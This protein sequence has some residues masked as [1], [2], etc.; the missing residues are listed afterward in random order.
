[1]VAPNLGHP[2]TIRDLQTVFSGLHEAR[3]KWNSIGLALGMNHG[4]LA[5]IAEQHRHDPD[6]CFKESLSCCLKQTEPEPTWEVVVSALESP[7]VG[8]GQLAERMKGKYLYLPIHTSDS[9][10]EHF[11][12]PCHRCDVLSY[13]DNGCP[14]SNSS[15]YPYLGLSKLD[16]DVKQDLVQTLSEDTANIIKGFANLLIT[17]GKSLKCRKV[18]VCEL[19]KVALDIGAY[20]SDKNQLPLLSEDRQK[21]QQAKSIDS[22][23]IMLGEH[24]FFQS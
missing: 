13:C 15:Q 23:F 24:V 6:K 16:E 10:N 4:D 9:N 3:Y 7:I 14:E 5:A 1:M 2:L 19:V 18:E 11:H 22:A 17:T 21:L 12:C 8:H 20:K